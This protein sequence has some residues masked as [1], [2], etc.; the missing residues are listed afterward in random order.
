MSILDKIINPRTLSED[1]A[2][3]LALVALL[4]G[5][6][7]AEEKKGYIVPKVGET[8]LVSKE[9]K[10]YPSIAGCQVVVSSICVTYPPG[11]LGGAYAITTPDGKIIPIHEIT[12]VG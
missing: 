9:H 8:V 3:R 6:K 10:E 1:G 11:Y 7:M 4:T 12:P 5:Y 2:E